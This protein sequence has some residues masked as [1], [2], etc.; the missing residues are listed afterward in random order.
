[1]T[2]GTIGSDARAVGGAILPLYAN[3]APDPDVFLK[4]QA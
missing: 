2:A 3:F 4:A 1:V